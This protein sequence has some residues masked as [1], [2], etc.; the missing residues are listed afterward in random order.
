[1]RRPLGA[2]VATLAAVVVLATTAAAV[3]MSGRDGSNDEWMPGWHGGHA[4][5]GDL[6]DNEFSYLTEMVTHHQEAV[7]AARH[8]ARSERPQM[9]AFG[10]DIVATQSAQINQMNGWLAAWYPGRQTE[11]DYRPMMRD[12]SGLEGDRLDR[13]FLQDMVVHH[14]AAVRMSQQ[15]LA[16]GSADHAD[17]AELART[18]RDA[19]HAEI[20][21]MQSWLT[22]WFGTGWHA[23]VDGHRS[24][25][26]ACHA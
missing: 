11:Q 15:L 13:A 21:Q 5:G 24:L 26:V 6:A 12:L 14:M 19:Q 9:R 22:A 7:D 8:L 20:F 17:V 1:M 10:R 23:M 3:S 2:L 25:S 4:M 18:I 16:R